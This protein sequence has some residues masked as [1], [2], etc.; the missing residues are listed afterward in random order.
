MLLQVLFLH[1]S[2]LRTPFNMAVTNML[3]GLHTMNI[4]NILFHVFCILNVLRGPRGE[5]S[6]GSPS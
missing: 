5:C 3:V 2:A 4:V 1:S 6:L